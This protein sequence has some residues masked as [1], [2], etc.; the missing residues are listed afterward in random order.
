MGAR[1]KF[2]V[3]NSLNPY[4][5]NIHVMFKKIFFRTALCL[6]LLFVIRQECSAQVDANNAIRTHFMDVGA[7]IGLDY[8]G[9]VG[10]KLAAILPFQHVSLFGAA[11]YQIFGFAWN[12][13]ATFH[14]FPENTRHTVRPN[15][16]IMYGINRATKVTGKSIYDGM[17]TGWTP[18]I[19]MA[20]RFGARRA[21]GF[22]LDLNV[23]IGS[24]KFNERLDAIKND[25]MV[26]DVIM[27]PVAF[28]IGYHHMF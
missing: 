7:G 6:A 25:P 5:I 2:M 20:F 17:F 11:G 4:S 3:R 23:P 9:L 19:G 15:I 22:D 1:V 10:V 14:I 28:S 16:K 24:S 13:G 12:A 8:G 21:N 26:T 18:G 27:L